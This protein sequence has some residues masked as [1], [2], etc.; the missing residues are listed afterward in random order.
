MLP[1]SKAGMRGI[2]DG[3]SLFELKGLLGIS[4]G[5]QRINVAWAGYN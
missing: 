1:F 2:P 5:L 3:T 4:R